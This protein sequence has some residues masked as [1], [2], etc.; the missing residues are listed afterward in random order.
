M[1]DLKVFFARQ[2]PL[3]ANIEATMNNPASAGLV[4]IIVNN[5]NYA[6]YIRHAVNS[7]LSQTYRPV[8][9]IVVDDGSTDNSREIIQE[10]QDLVMPVFKPNGGQGSAFNAGLA[11]CHG[12][13]VIFLDSD[14]VLLPQT[15]ERIVRAFHENPG[16]AK[17]EY[18][19][20]IIDA[21]G[22]PSGQVQPPA[23]LKLSNGDLRSQVVA[24]PF[25]LT[26]NATSGNAF[27]IHVLRQIAPVPEEDY[28]TLADFYLSHLSPLFG[29]VVALDSIGAYYRVHGANSFASANATLDLDHIRKMINYTKVTYS[30]IEHFASRLGLMPNANPLQ[31]HLSV[32]SIAERMISYKLARAQHPM[33]DD[34]LFGLL[35]LGLR[36]SLARFDVALP[37]KLLYAAWFTAIAIAPRRQAHWIAEKFYFPEKRHSLNRMLQSLHHLPT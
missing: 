26:W 9:L 19:M 22:M 18:R 16:T 17:V 6:P 13:Y 25:D 12:E 29:T 33:R 4:S 3:P 10:Y 1:S 30:Y 7:A 21:S 2:H 14:D 8:E 32:S 36:A 5:Y 27:D 24:F 11:A 20:E 35:H 15:V 28:P 34:T 31:Q 23:H 37:L